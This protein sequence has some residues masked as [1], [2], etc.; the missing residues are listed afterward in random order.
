LKNILVPS[1]LLL[2]ALL[3]C[4]GGSINFDDQ[5]TTGGP[6][7]LTNQYL[8]QGVL[9]QDISASQQFKFN[10]VPPSTPNYASPFFTDPNPGF[11]IF[12]APGNAAINMAYSTVS[13]T[14]VGLTT[15]EGHP[16][17]YS[18]ATIDAL[19]L[20]GNVIGGQ[21][22]VIPA[23]AIARPDQ[24]LTFTGQVH[25]LRFTLTNGTTG[26]FPIDNLTFAPEPSTMGL[27]GAS[28]GLLALTGFLRKLR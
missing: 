26:A 14:L 3:P 20:S 12:V 25:E 19:D 17:N 23:T 28:F 11:I 1:C 13:F 10:I 16:G 6:V 21:S 18:G 22:V 2:A 15:P 24:T 8:P 7:V 9:F 5:N 4:S 27:L